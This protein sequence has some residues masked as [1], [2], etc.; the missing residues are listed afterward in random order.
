MWLSCHTQ[1]EIAEAEDLAEGTIANRVDSFLK[2]GQVSKNEEAA[3]E[4]L[5]DFEPPI[6]N[7]WKQ[8]TKSEGSKYYGNSFAVSIV[9]RYS[10]VGRPPWGFSPEL[11][12]TIKKIFL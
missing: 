1:E 9:R 11:V 10:I 7:A 5:T 8:Q 12:K 6:Y 4:Y 2:F 3:A